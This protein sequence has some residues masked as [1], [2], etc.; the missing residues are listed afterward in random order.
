MVSLGTQGAIDVSA[1][2]VGSWSVIRFL[3]PIT[4]FVGTYTRYNIGN[5]E[6]G[7]V[8]M[9]REDYIHI[10]TALPRVADYVV[11]IKAGMKFTGQ[12]SEYNRAAVHALMGDAIAT[13]SNYVYPGTQ[14]CN[15]FFT[16]QALRKRACDGVVLEARIFKVHPGG[17][18]SIGSSDQAVTTP[19]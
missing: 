11:P 17:V 3:T 16:L 14:N 1:A 5:V 6:Q 8:E 7:V 15:T 19:M 2:I 4:P 18:F 12:L 9:N 10:G 13:S